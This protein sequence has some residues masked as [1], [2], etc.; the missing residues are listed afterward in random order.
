[1]ADIGDLLG[2]LMSDP[3]SVDKLSRIA[4]LLG[5][6]LDDEED[7]ALGDDCGEG[8]PPFGDS[9]AGDGPGGG[10]LAAMML[11]VL[12]LVN[13]YAASEKDPKVQLLYALRPYLTGERKERL[14]D[15][16]L[17]L[18]LSHIAGSAMELFSV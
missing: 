9:G 14:E 1:M 12:P 8:E 4:A 7:P 15:A 3:K 2:G 16:V 18:K 5:G 10:D 17:L 13:E 11:K 6:P